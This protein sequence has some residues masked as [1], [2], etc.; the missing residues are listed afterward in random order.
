MRA[1]VASACRLTMPKI[2]VSLCVFRP[3]LG[4]AE[5]QPSKAAG[6]CPSFRVPERLHGSL[7]KVQSKSLS[8]K[9]RAAV[10]AVG[11]A[12]TK[13]AARPAP[14]QALAQWRSGGGS[15][16][17]TRQRKVPCVPRAGAI[18]CLIARRSIQRARGHCP[19]CSGMPPRCPQNAARQSPQS[20]V[21]PRALLFL[22]GLV[23]PALNPL[24]SRL[25]WRPKPMSQPSR[26]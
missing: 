6:K 1:S 18:T 19:A 25:H 10:S 11:S 3:I 24:P 12:G 2:V 16:I 21:V 20:A 7:L 26:Q 8:P 13:P 23:L 9:C 17:E 14:Q 5:A 4:Q 15:A 22:L